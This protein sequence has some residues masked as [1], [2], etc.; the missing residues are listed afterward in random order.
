MNLFNNIIF[1][2]PWFLLLLGIIPVLFWLKSRRGLSGENTIRFSE[3]PSS[4]KKSNGNI[5]QTLLSYLPLLAIAF[6]IVALARPQRALQEEN[7]KSEGIDIV[8]VTDVSG[9]MLARDFEPNRLE[10][11]KNMGI[12]FI[13]DRN[14]DRIGLVVFAGESFTQC[15][16]TT[17]HKVVKKLFSEAKTGL[18]EDGTAIGM[19]LATAVSRLKESK[20][21][22]KVVILLTDGVNNSGFIDPMTAAETARQFGVK[23]YTIGVGTEGTAPFPQRTMFGTRYVNMKVEIDEELLLKIAEKTDGKYF[24][25]KDN[26]GLK[27]IYKEIDLLEKTEIDVT[28]IKRY[29][30]MFY[31]WT[32]WALLLV[33]FPLFLNLTLFKKII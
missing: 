30:E 13:G 29:S 9:S 27:T 33:A 21:D 15:P 24:R 6:L 4:V 14:F 26:E 25:A 32:R 11:A 17:D 2:D 20:S 16:I 19:G 5:L 22:S 3:V 18:M 12:E 7:I 8:I 28:R 10:A 1:D 31:P 23:V